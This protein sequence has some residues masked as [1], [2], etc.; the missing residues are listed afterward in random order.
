MPWYNTVSEYSSYNDAKETFD[1]SFPSDFNAARDCVRKHENGDSRPAL[2]QRRQDGSSR[3]FSFRYLDIKSNQLANYFRSH[4]LERGERVAIQV[5]QKPAALVGHLACWKLGLI[6][7][8]CSVLLGD[9]GLS[10]RLNHC[11]AK[12]IVVDSDQRETLSMVHDDC[13]ELEWIVETG[14]RSD[15]WTGIHDIYEQYSKDFD[16]VATDAETP[17]TILYTSGTTTNPKGVLH[18]HGFWV[19]NTPALQMSF[20]H[21]V[22]SA[23]GWTPVDWA[24]NGALGSLIFPLFHYGRPIVAMPRTKFDPEATFE[25]LSDF[26]VSHAFIPPT[27]LRLLQEGPPPEAYDLSLE[28]IAASGEPL[29]SEIYEW[30]ADALPGVVLNELYGLTEASGIV[31]NCQTWFE[32]K[33]GSAGRIVPG[34]DVAILD[35]ETAEK[36]EHEVEG[37]IA[38]RVAGDPAA[39][40]KYWRDPETTTESKVNGWFLTGDLGRLDEDGYLWF[41]SRADD[42]IVSSG[43]R[44]SPYEIE[45]IMYQH[46][47]VAGVGVVGMPDEVRGKIV[48]AFVE[49]ESSGGSRENLKEELQD[50]VRD[51]LA[52]YKY[53]REIEFVDSIPETHRGKIDRDRLDDM[54]SES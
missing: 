15:G 1:W 4:G 5:S 14:L 41:S 3:T 51:H 2:L 39:F 50:W 52:K 36:T 6:S 23:I 18:S 53:P 13:P 35:P 20:E 37:E 22:D 46:P 11:E 31:S 25:L 40:E 54:V 21:D 12:A 33:E 30:V 42:V 16:I 49:I 43:Y 47:A 34:H 10:Y 45:N 17:A 24:W 28:V 27:A 8:P 44:I 29:T 19:G 38:V 9:E 32:A 26:E 48:K 7:V